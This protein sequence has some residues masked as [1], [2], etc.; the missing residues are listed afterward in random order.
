MANLWGRYTAV[1]FTTIVF[2]LLVLSVLGQNFY[3]SFQ[4]E[5]TAEAVNIAGRQRMLSQRTAKSLS[6][7]QS[8]YL[9][10]RSVSTDLAEL[11]FSSSLFDRSLQAFTQ[12][13]ITASTKSGETSLAAVLEPEGKAILEEANQLWLPFYEDLTRMIS[14][15][16]SGSAG[17]NQSEVAALLAENMRYS[18][19]N[20]NTLL[21]L[22]NDLTNYEEGIAAS[23]ADRSRLIQVSGILASL[24]CFSIIL[25]LIFGQ[26]QRADKRAMR[27]QRET[28]QIF[29]T[30]DQGLF[31]IGPELRMGSQHSR[32][33]ERIFS[34]TTMAGQNF[35]DFISGL[36]S[37]AD[38]DKV[39][40]YLKL[41]FDPHKKQRLLT[42]LNPL[43]KLPVQ[44]E[45]YGE[46]V[47]KYL[48][49]SFSRVMNQG[50]IEG[51]L[52][53]VADISTEV[54]L[55]KDLELET[56]RNEQQLEMIGV[57]LG[58]DSDLLPEF[59]HGSDHTYTEIN[60]V[61]RDPARNS[62]EFKRKADSM[63][64]LVHSVK[65]EAAA[66]GLN[67]IAETCHEFESKID[68]LKQKTAIAGDDFLALTVML[69]RLISINEQIRAV[70]SIVN[71]RSDSAADEQT[72]SGMTKQ[73]LELA[74]QASERQHKKV[75]LSVAGFDGVDITANRKKD[76]Y[77]LASQLLRNAISHGIEPSEQRSSAGKEESGQVSMVLYQDAHGGLKLVCEDDGNGVDFAALSRKAVDQGLISSANGQNIKPQS[78]LNLM[79]Q[80]RLS[81]RDL[82]DVDAGRGAGLS[83]VGDTALKLG[84]KVSL[85][86]KP[87]KGTRFTLKIPAAA[88]QAKVV[89]THDLGVNYA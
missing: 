79:L 27:A 43:N 65:G 14:L 3:S 75:S 15:L 77:S 2:L 55:A 41:L 46:L 44:V 61:L 83:V 28:R 7:L 52:T 89:P 78:I 39:K 31:L 5:V 19:A 70:F 45:Q 81:S 86:T 59:M 84:A 54:K 73:L 9:A 82:V 13:G 29:E 51:V 1:I 53:S 22:M 25:W 47:N 11:K 50:K 67:I 63:M 33:L 80:N 38:L 69:D 35:S 57:L 68:E 36:V 6:N 26:L 85:Q 21:K 37:G 58:A 30:V 12:G 17:S 4:T 49:F 8:S 87:G 16:E 88:P 10:G 40:R 76:I 71:G 62:S 24:V 34:S 18:T 64:T 23:A 72:S 56:R 74:Q 60:N 66:L 48:R 42:D 20:I 32:E